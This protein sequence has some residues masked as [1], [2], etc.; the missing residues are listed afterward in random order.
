MTFYIGVFLAAALFDAAVVHYQRAVNA[1]KALTAGLWSVAVA[2]LGTLGVLA[3]VDVTA[4][5]LVPACAGYFVGTA[6]TVHLSKPK[7]KPSKDTEFVIEV[8]QPKNNGTPV[9]RF[10]E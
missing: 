5:L 2:L 3:M 7:Q 10:Y 1:H 9:F 8:Y 4:W 6:T